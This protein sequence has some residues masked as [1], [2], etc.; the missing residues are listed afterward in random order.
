[1]TDALSDLPECSYEGTIFPV[2]RCDWQ[3]GN[4]LV[5]HTA[6]RRPGADIEPTGWKAYRGSLV[7]PLVNADRLVARYGEL[8]PGLRYD[9]LRLFQ[10]T[11][12][13][14]LVHPT[15]G[16]LT[17][18]IGEISETTAP[19]DRGGV[20]LTVN[21]VEHDASVAL[22]LSDSAT[23]EPTD[24]V[25][26][27]EQLATEADTKVAAKA[28][29]YSPMASVVTERLAYLSAAVR[30]HTQIAESIERMLAPVTA[31]LAL[32]AL[33][34]ASAHEAATACFA[35]RAAIYALRDRLVPSALQQRFYVTPREM[36]LWEVS[37]AVYGRADY[38]QLLR[39][40]NSLGDP[41][42]VRAGKRLVVLPAPG[43]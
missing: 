26:S 23:G 20:R 2:E 16:R 12:I 39:A 9:L 17:V 29:T 5:E 13:G 18:G 15:L 37:L 6:Y 41:T 4:D 22:L 1:M 42:T 14:A 19:D 36:A 33:A 31:N 8:F 43:V 30:T 7:I 25:A 28:T 40:A 11:P 38:V 10:D 34:T 21:W 3:G 32:P 24:A 27:T 35:L